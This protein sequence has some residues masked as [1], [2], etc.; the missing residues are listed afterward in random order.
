M[1][2]IRKQALLYRN[3]AS[4][5]RYQAVVHLEDKEDE[6]FWNY[7]LQRT[8]PGHYRFLHYSKSDNGTDTHGCEQC[9]R[10]KPYLTDNFFICIDSDLRLLRGETGLTADK[11]IAQ[12]YTYSWENHFCEVSHLRERLTEHFPNADFDFQ[13][14]L[15][16]FSRIIYRPLLY[17]V[18]YGTNCNINQMWNISKFNACIPLQPKRTELNNNGAAYLA[19]VQKN[20]DKALECI[21]DKKVNTVQSLTEEN[22]YLHMQGHQLYKLVLHIGTM[23]CKGKHIAFRTDILDR[24]FHTE[25]YTEIDT[26]KCDLATML[27]KHQS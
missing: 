15:L 2:W 4:T 19:N 24:S 16:S 25:G 21:S 26:I 23:L 22:A 14:F 5:G 10:Y 1:D 7:Q 18:Q 17:L 13:T 27:Q 6:V 12:T 3:L 8:K 11:H 9:L 20:F